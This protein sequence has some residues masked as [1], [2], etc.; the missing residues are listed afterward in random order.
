M[1]TLLLR[2]LSVACALG[3]LATGYAQQEA[4]P[5]E[6]ENNGTTIQDQSPAPTA[7]DATESA[8]PEAA[9]AAPAMEETA[10][11]QSNDVST[12]A[13]PTNSVPTIAPNVDSRWSNELR[14]NFRGA[15]IELVL[16]YLSDAAGF[17]I[18]LNTPV[19][20]KVDVWSN[21]P[22]TRDE[23]VQLLN[24]VLNKNGYA[25]VRNGRTLTI[26]SK[27]DAIHGDIPV[28]I[29]NDPSTIPNND[30]I[31]TEIIPIRF[32][33]AEQLVKDLS[34]MTS[35]HATIVANEAG[36]SIVITDT[37][38]N[39]RHLAEIIK[40]IDS[41]AEDVTEVRVFHLKHHDPTELANLLTGLFS[42]QSSGT[43]NQAPIRFGG[44]GGPGGFRGG[45]FFGR[46]GG[47][48]AAAAT[49]ANSQSDRI[50]KRQQVVAV[51]DPRTS[52]VV[53]TAAKDMM[54]QIAGMVEQL[55]QESPGKVQQVSVIH[56]ENADPQQVQQVLQDM[57]QSSTTARSSSSTQLSPLEN[58]IQQNQG[59]M[60][61]T[62]G[63]N[64]STPGQS[65]SGAGLPTF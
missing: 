55:D 37:Q 5:A 30:E 14:L 50:K 59:S 35:P 40:A 61:G 45:G 22:V 56:L 15:P 36:N 18:Q 9:P 6:G 47:G 23:A 12:T 7:P 1:N 48:N 51:A 4:P 63:L 58:R 53:V 60:T 11:P 57:F 33:E 43:G 16:N 27:D 8:A 3:L 13:A 41:S 34:S 32:V 64:G 20:G 29:S 19:K 10:P 25:A 65:R 2:I 49:S 17:I 24:S 46:F 54:D 62:T 44:F 21:Q 31:V 26:M 38:A 39:I 42:D 28:K 52:S